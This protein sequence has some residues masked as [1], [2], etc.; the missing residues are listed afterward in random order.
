MFVFVKPGKQYFNFCGNDL[1][2]VL[3]GLVISIQI[4]KYFGYLNS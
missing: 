4:N 3:P 1:S 2:K